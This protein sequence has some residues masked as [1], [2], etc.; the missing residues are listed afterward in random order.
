MSVAQ[1]KN[2]KNKKPKPL[3]FC[4]QTHQ[5]V[6]ESEALTKII[7]KF[8]RNSDS[9]ERAC[10]SVVL[11]SSCASCQCWFKCCENTSH[12]VIRTLRHCW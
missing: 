2:K 6:T 9:S 3:L 8:Y 5:K 4:L 1:R 11:M 10:V 12:L 7:K